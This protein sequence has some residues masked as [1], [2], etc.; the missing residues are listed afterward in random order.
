[1]KKVALVRG[2]GLTKFE[3]QY[4]EPLIDNFEIWGICSLN[5]PFSIGGLKINVKKLP[6][7]YDLEMFFPNVFKLRKIYQR[8]FYYELFLQKIFG[9]E[10]LLKNFDIIHSADVE[11][12]YTYQS[13]K[14]R[15]KYD[16][17]LVITQWQNIP[18]AYGFRGYNFVKSKRFKKIVEAVDVAI[19]TSERAKLTLVLEGFPE[20][21]IQIVKPGVDV[22]KFRPM[23]KDFNLMRNLGINEDDKVI[24]FSGRLQ[25]QKGIIVLLNAFKLLVMDKDFD[26]NKLKLLIVGGGQLLN[27]LKKFVRFL[28]IEKNVIFAGYVDYDEMPK[29][30]NLADVFVL[31]SIPDKR[32][33][34]QFGMVLIESMACGKPVISTLSGSI[35][36]V[37]GDNAILVQSFD[38]FELY[39]ALKR[40]LSDEKLHYELGKR[41]REFVVKNY[42]AV[43]T[44][45]KIKKIYNS[46]I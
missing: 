43:D 14:A 38:F 45:Q 30:H 6:S 3:I 23:A 24:L 2:N 29:F 16:K 25:W 8:I 34:E 33:Q 5:N 32:W 20:E 11:Y 4:Y 39:K 46:L 35:P 41:G 13:A 10:N 17:R 15:L 36:E 19:A 7:V 37:V 12:F 9:L 27:W 44:A 1:M 31:P 21:K 40:I 18:F 22:E 26:G 42:N 28:D